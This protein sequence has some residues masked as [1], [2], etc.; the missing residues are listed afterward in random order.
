[1]T[2]AS[3]GYDELQALPDVEK[4][5]N[6]LIRFTKDLKTVPIVEWGGMPLFLVLGILVLFFPPVQK[7]Y[8]GLLFLLFMVSYGLK[9]CIL[10]RVSEASAVI[11]DAVDRVLRGE[12]DFIGKCF[13]ST[14]RE[15]PLLGEFFMMCKSFPMFAEAVMLVYALP[16]ATTTWLDQRPMALS[17]FSPP[18]ALW[19]LLAICTPFH[20]FLYYRFLWRALG[21]AKKLSKCSGRQFEIVQ[22]IKKEKIHD[23]ALAQNFIRLS[24]WNWINH[25]A[26]QGNLALV[27]YQAREMKEEISTVAPWPPGFTKHVS[28]DMKADGEVVLRLSD[29]E[30]IGKDDLGCERIIYRVLLGSGIRTQ[31]KILMLSYLI[32]DLDLKGKR[33]L[34]VSII[35]AMFGMALTLPNQLQ[36]VM[37]SA[38]GVKIETEFYG[39]ITTLLLLWFSWQLADIFFLGNLG[40]LYYL[41]ELTGA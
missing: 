11:K 7:Y 3:L 2:S 9:R 41:R 8:Y 12:T 21:N 40:F 32:N 36:V 5:A 19:V 31:L 38:G 18:A 4:E 39:F 13:Q 17:A 24:F 30:F 10:R 37:K 28:F 34:T 25:L 35:M 6:A 16:E 14:F 29:A 22:D 23:E 33:S 20:V 27:S 26:G 1:M 15:Y